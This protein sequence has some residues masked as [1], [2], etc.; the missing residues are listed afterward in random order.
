[1]RIGKQYRIAAEDLAALAGRPVGAFPD[2][3]AAYVS[4]FRCDYAK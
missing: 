1:M 2:F 3:S 4:V